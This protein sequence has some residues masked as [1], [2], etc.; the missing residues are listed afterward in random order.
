LT[1][2][3]AQT[4]IG[5]DAT[6]LPLL[7]AIAADD[8]FA[9]GATTTRYL[10]EREP[11]LVLA[12]ERAGEDAALLAAVALA[13]SGYAWRPAG[14]GV[15]LVFERDGVTRATTATRTAGGWRL[16]GDIEAAVAVDRLSPLAV[17]FADR[18]IVGDVRRDM[19]GI[20]VSIDGATHRFAFPGPPSAAAAPD[21][22]RSGSGTVSAPMPGKVVA[23]NARAGVAVAAGDA[24][25]VLEAMKMEHRIDAPFAGTVRE[26][27]VAPGDLVAGGSILLSIGSA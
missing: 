21:K 18:R 17:R 14:T 3:L 10:E 2:T 27:H 6:N 19:N 16:A 24:L 11:A 15:P 23:V 26:V 22:A 7:R 13:G 12:S 1:T 8:A 20:D 9:A 4:R 25:V 5:G